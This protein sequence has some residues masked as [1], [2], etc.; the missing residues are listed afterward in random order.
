MSLKDPLIESD[1]AADNRLQVYVQ[2]GVV[3]EVWIRI[4]CTNDREGRSHKS[5]FIRMDLEGI[6]EEQSLEAK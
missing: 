5:V 3:E 1:A 4:S 6:T 2:A